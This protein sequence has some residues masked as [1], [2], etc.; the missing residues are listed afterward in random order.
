MVDRVAFYAER[1]GPEA[2]RRERRRVD[3]TRAYRD[4]LE[5]A[6]AELR[7]FSE[8][9]RDAAH[10]RETAATPPRGYWSCLHRSDRG[11][12]QVAHP[13][14]TGS[15]DATGSGTASGE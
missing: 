13:D 9:R 6:R 1:E 14:R 7:A 10:D 2:A 15:T 4:I 11:W 5:K 8:E 3:A 12:Q